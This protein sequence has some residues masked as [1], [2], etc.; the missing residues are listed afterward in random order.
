VGL[1]VLFLGEIVGKAGVYCI[2]NELTRLK[3]EYSVDFVIANG[4]GATGGFGLGKNHSIY[5]HKLGIDAITGGDQI[6]Y[7]KDMVTHI[8]KAPYILRPANFPPGTPGRGWRHFPAGD[9][10]IA[11]LSLLGQSG[12]SKVHGSNPFTFL[13]EL[14][15]RIKKDTN[16]IVLDFHAVTTAEKY[17]MFYVADGLA[18]AVVGTGQ[19][20]LTADATIMEHG[21]GVIC[22]AGRTG[23]IDS[24]SGLSPQIEIDKLIR[25][26]PERSK[27][28]WERLE[29]QGVIMEFDDDARAQS[30][31]PFRHPCEA[32]QGTQNDDSGG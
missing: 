18:S 23:S 32:A 19:R 27:E 26:I 2:K 29:L 21:T 1:R 6:Y 10:R 16:F 13:P 3:R 20:V 12:Y 9:H 31:Q 28:W 22:D 25:Q 15:E 17:T 4:D 11:V 7:K 30:I 14:V 8:A 24:V 5:L